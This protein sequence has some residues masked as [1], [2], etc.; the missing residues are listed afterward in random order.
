MDRGT[1]Q[2]PVHRVIEGSDRTEQ[3]NNNTTIV[4][5][6]SQAYKYFKRNF[7]ECIWLSAWTEEPG[8]QRTV[9]SVAKRLIGLN[10]H[11]QSLKGIK[12]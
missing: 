4:A 5:C 11:A 7:T 12:F 9:H 6:T 2:A 3:L 10:T 8:G 1:W